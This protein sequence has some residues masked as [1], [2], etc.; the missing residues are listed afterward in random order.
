MLLL[1]K[2]KTFT[3]LLYHNTFKIALVCLMLTPMLT[4]V[5]CTSEDNSAY[6]QKTLNLLPTLEGENKANYEKNLV[7]FYNAQVPKYQEFSTI[8]SYFRGKAKIDRA[9]YN[10]IETDAIN[11]ALEFYNKVV[12]QRKDTGI[13]ANDV[14]KIINLLK[15]SIKHKNEFEIN[16]YINAEVY[17]DALATTDLLSEADKRGFGLAGLG[18]NMLGNIFGSN[19]KENL[20]KNLLRYT[21]MSKEEIQPFKEKGGEVAVFIYPTIFALENTKIIIVDKNLALIEAK[22]ERDFTAYYPVAD[23]GN[24]LEIFGCARTKAS[25]EE[26]ARNTLATVEKITPESQKKLFEQRLIEIQEDIARGKEISKLREQI[27]LFR[28]ELQEALKANDI[29]KLNEL[30]NFKYFSSIKA[31][32]KSRDATTMPRIEYDFSAKS[33][34]DTNEKMLG[35]TEDLIEILEDPD[36]FANNEKN[37]MLDYSTIKSVQINRDNKTRFEI[38]T[39]RTRGILVLEQNNGK[40]K[41]QYALNGFYDASGRSINSKDAF[42]LYVKNADAITKSIVAKSLEAG[43]IMKAQL[44]M[45]EHLYSQLVFEDISWEVVL[46]NKRT[47]NILLMIDGILYNKSDSNMTLKEIDLVFTKDDEL[48]ASYNVD[49]EESVPVNRGKKYKVNIRLDEKDLY[50]LS[51]VESG[52]L[53]FKI[54]AKKYVYKGKSYTLPTNADKLKIKKVSDKW[55]SEDFEITEVK[56][57]SFMIPQTNEELKKSYEEKFKAYLEENK[58]SSMQLVNSILDNIKFTTN[59]ENGVLHVTIQ[60]LN[61]F[62]VKRPKVSVEL[63]EKNIIINSFNLNFRQ[64]IAANANYSEK[65]NFKK[66]AQDLSSSNIDFTM[67]VNSISVNDYTLVRDKSFLI[68]GIIPP[69]LQGKGNVL[70]KSKSS[71]GNKQ[72]STEVKL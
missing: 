25:A 65:I 24:G 69:F 12:M 19:H 2:S 57:T 42:E 26:F 48:I 30:I 55:V 54:I 13:R 61:N 16:R 8:I 23:F 44:N 53:Q 21:L 39:L 46:Q 4:L 34:Y 60:N 29:K 56:D 5:A 59:Y 40:L 27:K 17:L 52:E 7:A 32:S 22:G 64:N 38:T 36:F 11:I 47:N 45:L 15:E 20:S 50:Y 3:R 18:A 49:H 33:T 63:S 14:E 35:V 1:M 41:A 10:K 72:P 58:K 71:M 67:M 62:A 70:F 68:E 66:H 43:D 28:T 31:I 6:V 51:L 9:N 37:I